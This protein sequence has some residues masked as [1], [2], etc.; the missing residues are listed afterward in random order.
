MAVPRVGH[1]KDEEER[2]PKMEARPLAP[3]PSTSLRASGRWEAEVDLDGR[4]NAEIEEGFLALRTA[5]G[6]TTVGFRRA[7]FKGWQ[8][9]A[10]E[11]SG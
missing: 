1:Y 3:L 2:H 11:R 6:M 10:W 5:L 8:G 7:G 9:R 4:Q